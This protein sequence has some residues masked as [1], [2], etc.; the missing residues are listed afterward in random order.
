MAGRAPH[1]LARVF[2][3]TASIVP[4]ALLTLLPKCPLC[5]AAWLAVATGFTFTAA[6]VAWLRGS[7][8]LFWLGALA[9]IIVRRRSGR[10]PALVPASA[11]RP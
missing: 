1:L 8:A 9:V 7:I 4:A 5:L 11:C 10:K 3:A 6:G 2:E